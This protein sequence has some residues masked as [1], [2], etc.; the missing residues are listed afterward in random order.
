MVSPELVYGPLYGVPRIGMG[1][2]M[3]LRQGLGRKT[4]PN[5]LFLPLKELDVCGTLFAW[6]AQGMCSQGMCSVADDGMKE[7]RHMFIRQTAPGMCS[8]GMCS[9]ADDGMKEVHH[10]FILMLV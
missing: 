7:V 10:L 2:A 1:Q 9:V 4:S 6:V 5:I 3:Q 8:Q